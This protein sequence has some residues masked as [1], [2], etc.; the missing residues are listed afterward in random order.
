MSV[1]L[2]PKQKNTLHRKQLVLREAARMFLEQGYEVT[3]IKDISAAT[4]VSVG[5]IYHFYESKAAILRELARSMMTKEVL[6]LLDPVPERLARCG[7]VLLEY[8]CSVAEKY[9]RIGAQLA[10]HIA[11]DFPA[12]WMSPDGTFNRHYLPDELLTFLRRA[13]EEGYLDSTISSEEA[14]M[15]LQM[16]SA[17]VLSLWIYQ[18]GRFSLRDQI[19]SFMR[20]LIGTLT[21]SL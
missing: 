12:I 7:Q 4:G 13:Q 11:D 17:G 8:Y 14:A 5:S 1:K 21:V 2:T 18:K 16:G 19:E 6:S 20:R 10:K 3:T 15:I 9:D